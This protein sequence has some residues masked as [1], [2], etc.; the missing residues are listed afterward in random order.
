MFIVVV[1][2]IQECFPV[3]RTIQ[4]MS[5]I[6]L[7]ELGDLKFFFEYLLF[8]LWYRRSSY[9]HILLIHRTVPVKCDVIFHLVKKCFAEGSQFTGFR[10][11]D[12]LV[13]DQ[14]I[15]CFHTCF[16]VTS[17][18]LLCQ[19][20]VLPELLSLFDCHIHIKFWCT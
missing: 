4:Y 7:I 12:R 2:F 20:F 10:Q 18:E 13:V 8:V 19:F 11:P 5:H 14:F 1:Q 6:L 9:S 16:F 15:D 17:Q 3:Y